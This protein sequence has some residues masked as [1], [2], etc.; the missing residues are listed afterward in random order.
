MGTVGTQGPK[1]GGKIRRVRSGQVGSMD[2]DGRKREEV[3]NY[4]SFEGEQK[5]RT[6]LIMILITHLLGRM[7]LWHW[8]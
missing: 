8:R 1:I 7:Y 6:L 5:T 3:V 4:V 2:T